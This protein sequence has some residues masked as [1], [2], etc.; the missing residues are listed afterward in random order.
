MSEV[1]AHNI[2]AAVDGLANEIGV[3][4]ASTNQQK[5]MDDAP[6]GTPFDI[7]YTDVRDM[8]FAEA[9]GVL[10]DYLLGDFNPSKERK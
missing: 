10:L 2:R 6:A 7:I 1:M 8:A 5:I 4:I 3:R 9:R